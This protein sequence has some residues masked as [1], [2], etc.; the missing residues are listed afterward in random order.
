MSLIKPIIVSFVLTLLSTALNVAA[1]DTSYTYRITGGNGVFNMM[2]IRQNTPVD[3]GGTIRFSN[4][5]AQNYSVTLPEITPE[6]IELVYSNNS[7]KGKMSVWG[8]EAMETFVT[9]F[10]IG[11]PDA[12][13]EFKGTAP[14]GTLQMTMELELV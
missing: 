9:V 8:G 7:W 6:L 12:V 3:P 4:T 11:T 10:G 13:M 14:M 5:S 1:A 2:G